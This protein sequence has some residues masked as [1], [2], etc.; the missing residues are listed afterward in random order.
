[1]KPYSVTGGF[2]LF[3]I[4]EKIFQKLNFLVGSQLSKEKKKIKFFLYQNPRYAII[5]Y[6]VKSYCS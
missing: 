4:L 1:M 3:Q 2:F 5:V 6:V